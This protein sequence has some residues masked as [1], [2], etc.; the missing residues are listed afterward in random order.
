MKHREYI[1]RVPLPPGIKEIVLPDINGDYTIY[2]DECLSD[3]Q[4][5]KEYEHA[6]KHIDGNH[7]ELSSVQ[8]IEMLAH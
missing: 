4:A 1:Y 5:L 3:E 8:Q 7:W 6:R 2:I